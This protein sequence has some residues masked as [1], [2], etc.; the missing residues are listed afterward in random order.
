MEPSIVSGE[1]ANEEIGQQQFI[2]RFE[3]DIVN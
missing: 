1:M 3:S 2:E